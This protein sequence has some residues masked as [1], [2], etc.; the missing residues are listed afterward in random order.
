M[1]INLHTILFLVS[2][3][4]A[5]PTRNLQNSCCN[6]VFYF[7]IKFKYLNHLISHALVTLVTL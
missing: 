1:Q 7:L 2:R 3:R 6:I 5:F 4:I